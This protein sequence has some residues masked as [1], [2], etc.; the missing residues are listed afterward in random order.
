MKEDHI[1][2]ML[3]WLPANQQ[4][5][6]KSFNVL[7]QTAKCGLK[8]IIDNKTINMTYQLRRYL[9]DTFKKGCF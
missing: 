7:K 9:K 1:K 8:I 6:V 2:Q 4:G 3:T 5:R